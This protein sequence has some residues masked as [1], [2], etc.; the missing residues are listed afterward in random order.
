MV[1]SHAPDYCNYVR[2][3]NPA[4]S[5]S[6]LYTYFFCSF[7]FHLMSQFTSWRWKIIWCNNLYHQIFYW[8]VIFNKLWNQFLSL[9][10]LIIMLYSYNIQWTRKVQNYIQHFLRIVMCKFLPF[11]IYGSLG[12]ISFNLF[13]KW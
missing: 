2:Y 5:G 12:V 10:V 7:Y 6:S 8:K 9:C 11:C 4:F 1:K 13:T 3:H